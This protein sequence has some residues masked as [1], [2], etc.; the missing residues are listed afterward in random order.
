MKTLP[1]LAWAGPAR[2]NS[3]AQR[4]VAERFRVREEKIHT[5]KQP[6]LRIPRA[7][8]P[9]GQAWDITCIT[10]EFGLPHWTGE[11]RRLLLTSRSPEKIYQTPEFFRFLYD[12]QTSSSDRFELFAIR[13]RSLDRIVGMVPV[14]ISRVT[15]DFQVGGL[16]LLAYA[17]CIVRLLGSVALAPDDAALLHQLY[18]HLLRSFPGCAAVS[19]QALPVEAAVDL[20]RERRHVPFVVH[21]WRPCHTVPLPEDLPAY[22][23]KLSGK[24]R[25]NLNRQY[26]VLEAATGPLTLVRIDRST[27]VRELVDGI[28]ALTPGDLRSNMGAR[29]YRVLAANRLLLSYVLRSA[30][31]V[32]AVVTGSRYGDT[33]HVHQILYAQ[34]YRHLSAGS[35]AM[36]AALQ[37]VI[38]HFAFTSAD[39]GFGTPRHQFASTHALK[40]RAHVLV[41]RRGAFSTL[42]LRAYVRVDAFNAACARVLKPLARR[43][44]TR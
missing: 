6:A 13:D 21:G 14:R 17:P 23:A 11:W 30:G 28:A 42:M 10:E 29:D 43:L 32:V 40:T 37:D 38:A 36:H 4:D 24:K 34:A 39:F 9:A 41:A 16:T 19:M 18:A 15:F 3:G 44:A 31:E 12:S 33:W 7:V 25:Y 27:Q 20:D 1:R 26:R 8:A 2:Q 22:L 5:A 35:I